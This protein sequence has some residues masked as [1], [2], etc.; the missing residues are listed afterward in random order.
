MSKGR[1]TKWQAFPFL[2]SPPPP[3]CFHQCCARPNFCAAK[4]RKTPTT[5]GN[6]CYAGYF[7]GLSH[8]LRNNCFCEFFSM[9]KTLN[10]FWLAQKLFPGLNFR[11]PNL[12]KSL[13]ISLLGRHVTYSPTILQPR[14][15]YISQ[16]WEG[17]VLWIGRPPHS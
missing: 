14:T 13:R 11:A 10:A 1:F 8:D 17:V 4:K 16:R 7:P 3:R 12:R 15:G 9:V 6:A 5:G 2:A